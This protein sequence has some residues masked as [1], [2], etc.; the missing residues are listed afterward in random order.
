MEPVHMGI[1]SIIP[2]IIAIALSF[3]TRNTVISLMIAIITGTILAGQGIL[4]FPALLRSS[5]GTSGFAWVM[6]LNTFIGVLVAF[7]QKTGA[8]QGFSQYMQDRNLSRKAITLVAWLLGFVVYF[9]DS[10]SPL[11]VG[12]TMRNISDKAKISREKLAYIADSGAAPVS[13]IVPITGWAAFLS[14]LA[15]GVGNI[16]TQDDAMKLFI[17]AIPFNLY[18]LI[19]IVF[20]GLVAGGVIKDFGPMKKAED[21]AMNEGKVLR[22]GAIPLVGKEL[23]EMEA[24]PDI[25][26]RI[27]LNFLFPVMLIIAIALGTYV[28]TRSAKTMEAFLLVIIFMFV[29]M[30]IQGIPMTVIMDAATNGIKGAV[31]AIMILALAYT[32]KSLSVDMG[33]AEFI[34]STTEGFLTPQILPAIIFLIAA[35]VAFSTGTSWGTFAITMP[36]ALPLAFN[37]SGGV[38]TP[39]VMASFAAVAGGGVFGDHCSPLS[40][41]TILAS[42]GAA[43]DHIDHVKT[44][45]PYA[46]ITGGIA[47]VAY[48]VIGFTSF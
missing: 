1:I 44:Q 31:P 39:L 12:S 16:V 5:I 17:Q 38:V 48:L 14:G 21:R 45:L 25:K 19:T 41:T 11:F 18:A 30:L 37:F 34:I 46:L 35:I 3:Y 29:S 15:I 36:I 28:L 42:T 40:D 22:D 33:T 26:P 9:S 2:A 7:F 8:I 47:L 20:V 27:F 4:G 32:I 10:F 23:T 6:L 43:A 24:Y 13:V